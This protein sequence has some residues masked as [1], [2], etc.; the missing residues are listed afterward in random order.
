MNS[1]T[2]LT[3]LIL[4][5]YVLGRSTKL[6]LALTIAST[7]AGTTAAKNRD[8]LL[9]GLRGFAESSP[10]LKS[11]QEKITGRLA[12]SGRSA[13]RAVAAKGVDQ[14]SVRL[15]EQTEKMKSSLDDAA[16]SLDPTVDDSEGPDGENNA[17]ETTRDTD[18]EY[19]ED[20]EPFE[21]EDTEAPEEEYEGEYAEDE[22]VEEDT[23]EDEP[24]DEERLDED[25]PDDID[26]EE[27]RA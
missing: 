22:P 9:S 4:A 6:G 10:E 19:A 5:G 13:A 11:L 14:L 21:A 8:Q 2:K 1:K 7:V 27:G 17:A 12:E 3:G 26:D 15:Q 23:P 25:Q 18:E 24:I 20:E 16:V